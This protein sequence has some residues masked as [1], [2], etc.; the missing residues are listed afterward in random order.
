MRCMKSSDDNA[1]NK[2]DAKCSTDATVVLK[3]IY[4]IAEQITVSKVLI[5][6]LHCVQPTCTAEM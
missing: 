3:G 1:Y 4:C 5:E 2:C 6:L